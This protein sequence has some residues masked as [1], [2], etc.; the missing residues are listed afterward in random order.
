MSNPLPFTPTVLAS[1]LPHRGSQ[2]VQRT[3]TAHQQRSKV[4]F[5]SV[6]IIKEED[7][8]FILNKH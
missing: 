6:Y 4:I 1:L 8:E 3:P 2:K 5:P 7:G